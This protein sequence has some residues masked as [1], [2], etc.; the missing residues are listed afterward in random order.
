MNNN[1][2]AAIVAKGVSKTYDKDVKALKG[3][4]LTMNKGE[5]FT[6][7]GPNGAG[8][9]TFLRI[10]CTQLMPTS[11]DAHILG[12]SV[13]SDPEAVRNNIAMVPQDAMA[14]ANFT[15]WDYA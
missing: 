4:D 2:E 14:Y 5:V 6:I 12:D 9:T 7:L 8:K 13:L 15:P 10:L 11:G 1:H 3:M